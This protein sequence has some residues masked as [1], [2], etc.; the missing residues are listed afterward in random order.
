VSIPEQ[1]ETVKE[2]AGPSQ[3]LHPAISKAES[4]S[5]SLNTSSS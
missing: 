4:G 2:L 5:S 3:V 1:K